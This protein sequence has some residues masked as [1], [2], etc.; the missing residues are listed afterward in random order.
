MVIS[1]NTWSFWEESL[2]FVWSLLTCKSRMPFIS[3]VAFLPPWGKVDI[4][5]SVWSLQMPRTFSILLVV[6]STLQEETWALALPTVLKRS[7]WK[8]PQVCPPSCPPY[9]QPTRFALFMTCIHQIVTKASG[10]FPGKISLSAKH[11]MVPRGNSLF[12]N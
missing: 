12:F 7:Q 9:H 6:R 2:D 4:T 10:D 5:Q 3:R 1:H 8:I 11:P